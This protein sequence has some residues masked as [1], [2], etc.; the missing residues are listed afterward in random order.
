MKGLEGPPFDHHHWL[1]PTIFITLQKMQAS[2]NISQTIPMG[3]VA[4]RLPSPYGA[5]TLDVKLVL[6]ENLGGILGGTHC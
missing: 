5:F 6:N 4:S 3:L 1:Q 2:S